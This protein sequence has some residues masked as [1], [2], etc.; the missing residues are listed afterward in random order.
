MVPGWRGREAGEGGGGKEGEGG[1]VNLW[2]YI[3]CVDQ[4]QNS[5]L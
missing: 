1:G 4:F 3:H 5:K 2:S